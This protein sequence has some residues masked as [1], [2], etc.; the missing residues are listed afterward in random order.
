MPFVS[1]RLNIS[2]NSEQKNVL[3]KKIS[4]AVAALL[5]KPQAY[6]MSEIS[7]NC[8]LYMNKEALEFGAYISI[9]MLGNTTKQACSVLTQDICRIL[10]KDYGINSANVYITYHPVDLWG[11]NGRMF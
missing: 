2:L 4:D 10:E 9:S 3:Q 6:I 1:V 11:W 7:D 8:A 5:S